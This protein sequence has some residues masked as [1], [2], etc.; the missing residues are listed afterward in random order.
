MEWGEEKVVGC[1]KVQVLVA[2]A[3]PPTSPHLN[4]DLD[5][6]SRTAR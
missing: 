5:N 3:I 6:S 2:L 1:G 4:R